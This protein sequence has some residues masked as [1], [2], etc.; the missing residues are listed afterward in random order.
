MCRQKT[1]E[2]QGK[3]KLKRNLQDEI[4][5]YREDSQNSRYNK[6]SVMIGRTPVSKL[7]EADK[8]M[9]LKASEDSKDSQNPRKQQEQKDT[10]TVEVIN[11]N[12]CDQ[13]LKNVSESREHS[14]NCGGQLMHQ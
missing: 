3:V 2:D 7:V 5:K 14:T 13:C 9:T 8:E 1:D 12:Q 6:M 4:S 11:S 10:E